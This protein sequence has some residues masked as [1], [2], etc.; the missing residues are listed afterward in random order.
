LYLQCT[1]VRDRVKAKV[2]AI[3]TI[4]NH[5]RVK[6]EV[7]VELGCGHEDRVRVMARVKAIVYPGCG[8]EAVK[9]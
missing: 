1:W 3:S 6:V 7:R 9:Y 2:T 4:Y 5:S 8:H